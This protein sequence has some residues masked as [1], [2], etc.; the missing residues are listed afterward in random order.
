MI[1]VLTA[2][3]QRGRATGRRRQIVLVMSSRSAHRPHGEVAA[4]ATSSDA[5]I[6]EYVLLVQS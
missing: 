2:R 5:I 4:M 1:P 6:G 3:K